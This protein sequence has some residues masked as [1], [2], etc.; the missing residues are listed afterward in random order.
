M[1]LPR[2]PQNAKQ[3]AFWRW[4]D[5][6]PID[7]LLSCYTPANLSSHHH[8]HTH[9]CPVHATNDAKKARSAS[10]QPH[11]VLFPEVGQGKR[12]EIQPFSQESGTPTVP[13]L[14][15]IGLHAPA[16]ANLDQFCNRWSADFARERL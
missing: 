2:H 8:V 12:H 9:T 10:I 15:K 14:F 16:A 1:P 4:R 5:G 11:I 6:A 7:V 13:Q 3:M